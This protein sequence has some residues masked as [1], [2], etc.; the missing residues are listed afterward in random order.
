MIY[1]TTY[2]HAAGA[3]GHPG[4][5]FWTQLYAIGL[6]MVALLVCLAL[7]YRMLA[8]HSLFLYGGLVALLIYVLV[9]GSTQMGAHA[10]DR[11]RPV[12]PAAVGV[13]PHHAWR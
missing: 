10:L 8:E 9:Q 4:P 5:Q 1:S 2:V 7:D 12:Q 3:G 11:R 13:R 6:G